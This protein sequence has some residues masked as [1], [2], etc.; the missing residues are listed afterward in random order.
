MHNTFQ[1]N[2]NATLN[3]YYLIVNIQCCVFIYY[4]LVIHNFIPLYILKKTNCISMHIVCIYVFIHLWRVG[5]FKFENIRSR[6]FCRFRV[7]NI[8]KERNII[9]KE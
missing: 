8:N 2:K 1:I 6:N 9:M 5:I 7:I 3:I 4:L